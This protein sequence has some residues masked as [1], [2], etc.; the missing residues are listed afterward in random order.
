MK[1][2]LELLQGRWSQVSFEENG[3]KDAPD[4]HGSPRAVMTIAGCRFHVAVPGEETLIEGHFAMDG[5][6]RPKHID[7]IDSM[8]DDAGKVIPSIFELEKDSFRFAAADPDMAR[9]KNFTG[10]HGIT[11][12]AFVRL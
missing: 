1:S 2:D 10:G 4:T 8:G 9:P 5:A 3:T 11:I 7:W 12:R 6:H